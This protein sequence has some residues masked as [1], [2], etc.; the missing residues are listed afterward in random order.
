M[1]N[2]IFVFVI[3]LAFVS[4]GMGQQIIED[5]KPGPVTIDLG[6]GYEASFKLAD[7][8]D[9]YNIEISEPATNELLGLKSTSYSAYISGVD[10][11]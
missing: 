11:G 6:D 3:S 2:L 8:E 5:L 4:I 9:S 10:S 7:I 1:R